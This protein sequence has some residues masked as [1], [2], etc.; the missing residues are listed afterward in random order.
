MK[1]EDDD[2]F[3]TVVHEINGAVELFTVCHAIEPCYMTHC[4]PPFATEPRNSLR[5]PHS[6]PRHVQSFERAARLWARE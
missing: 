5:A 4:L 6:I 3:L 1:K 2:R